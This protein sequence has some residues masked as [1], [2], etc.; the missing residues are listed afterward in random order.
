MNVRPLTIGWFQIQMRQLEITSQ[1]DNNNNS[2]YE[3]ILAKIDLKKFPQYKKGDCPESYRFW[4][5]VLGL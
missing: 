4:A 2:S 5:R 1:N 3:G